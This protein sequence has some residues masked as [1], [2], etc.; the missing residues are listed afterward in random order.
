M[1]VIIY[2]LDSCTHCQS[3][4]SELKCLGWN[5]E[6]FDANAAIH[7]N[8]LDKYGVERLPFVQLIDDSGRVTWHKSGDESITLTDII[9]AAEAT[10]ASQK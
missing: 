6:V 9:N 4:V 2:A 1:K 10:H 5:L 7:Q 8:T 3:I